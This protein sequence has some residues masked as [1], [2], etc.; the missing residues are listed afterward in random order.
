MFRLFCPD[1]TNALER[2]EST[3]TRE[4]LRELV[5]IQEDGQLRA[6]TLVGLVV[7]PADG[8]VLEGA[9]HAFDLTVGPRMVDFRK[10][11]LDVTL[12]AG[13]VKGVRATRL[14]RGEH[15][16]SLGDT[17]AAAGRS[18]LKAVVGEHGMNAVRDVV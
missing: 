1:L 4:A 2:G 17:P 14:M 9:I 12:S 18:E 10:P 15:L 7:E 11:M 16:L 13:Q 5:R 6:E 3:E 8:G